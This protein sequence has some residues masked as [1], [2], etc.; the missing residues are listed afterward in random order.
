MNFSLLENKVE[1]FNE[2]YKTNLKKTNSNTFTDI[3]I[4]RLYFNIQ[5]RRNHIE[6]FI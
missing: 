1:E 4:S 6:N 3:I 2:L 5:N